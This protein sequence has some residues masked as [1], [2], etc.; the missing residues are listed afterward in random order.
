MTVDVRVRR[1]KAL[2]HISPQCL[3]VSQIRNLANSIVHN[4]CTSRYSV[5][6]VGREADDV[7][8][9]QPSDPVTI[10]TKESRQISQDFPGS[11]AS[12]EF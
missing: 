2:Q 11:R 12:S 3:M 1:K 8:G 4:P 6:W 10:M 5:Q 9:T 7:H